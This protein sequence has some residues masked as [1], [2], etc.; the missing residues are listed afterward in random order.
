MRAA[1]LRLIHRAQAIMHFCVAVVRMAAVIMS[2][3][4]DVREELLADTRAIR[5]IATTLNGL[6]ISD[7]L[8]HTRMRARRHTALRIAPIIALGNDAAHARRRR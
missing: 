2:I 7:G 3:I 6:F 8:T 1:Q 5:R 4:I